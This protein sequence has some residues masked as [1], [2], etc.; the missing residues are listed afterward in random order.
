M[1]F[2]ALLTAVVI[3]IAVCGCGEQTGGT[4]EQR[5]DSALGH[6]TNYDFP[7]AEPLLDSLYDT[8]PEDHP[9]RA[10]V[11]YATGV[12]NWLSQPASASS[13]ARGKEILT[14][15][16]NN[17][18]DTPFGYWAE[19]SLARIAETEDYPGDTKDLETARI[20]YGT[21][22]EGG[23]PGFMKELASLRL[24]QTYLERFE[25]PESVREGRARLEALISSAPDSKAAGIAHEVL[26]AE[27]RK[28]GEPAMALGHLLEAERI[29]LGNPNSEPHTVFHMARIAEE[30]GDLPLAVR[31]YRKSI[32][33]IARNP[34]AWDAHARLLELKDSHPELEID[35]PEVPGYADFNLNLEAERTP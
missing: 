31:L 6:I 11:E 34:Y 16:L 28:E 10:E 19:F 2:P 13:V 12:V 20:H 4:S 24:A 15:L 29:G 22:I 18:P 26:A 14:D 33:D 35:V 7:R 25:D 23:A 3:V 32:L 21:L 17:R 8:L 5:L 1:K 27:Y 30:S 9:R